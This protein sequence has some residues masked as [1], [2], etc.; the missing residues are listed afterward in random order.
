MFGTRK[1]YAPLFIL[2]I[3]AFVPWFQEMRRV[4]KLAEEAR[5]ASYP[6]YTPEKAREEHLWVVKTE[7]DWLNGKV[8][9]PST[10]L[11][12]WQYTERKSMLRDALVV[13]EGSKD[14]RIRA[15][16][17]ARLVKM[18]TGDE[19]T[20]IHRHFLAI[21][22]QEEFD[23]AR[24]KNLYY[25]R[26]QPEIPGQELRRFSE[27]YLYSIP[28]MFL[29]FVIR[30]RVRELMIWTE[31][32]RLIPA[33]IFW[34]IALFLYPGD[35]RRKEQLKSAMYFVAQFA[36]AMM[37]LICFGPIVPAMKAQI[38]KSGKNG[39]ER[40]E[41]K[42]SHTFAYGVEFYPQSAGID[43]GL[44]I[45][46]WYAHSHQLGKGFT[47]SGFGFIEAGE[48]KSQLFTNH[49]SN[50]SHEKARG[51]MFTWEIGGTTAGAFLGIGPRFNLVKLPFFPKD[52]KKIVKSVV[53]GSMWQIRGPTHYREFFLTWSSQEARLP[54]GFRL[55]TEGFM[56]FR[57][58][59]RTNVGQ[60]Q[61]LLRHPRIPH[62]QFVSE[63]WMIG[64]QP[65]VRLGLQ[66]SK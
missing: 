22:G 52:G 24:P 61:L 19:M 32:W 1:W 29:V 11:P 25:N 59:A 35:I 23:K 60:P 51:G 13:L 17:G 5:V 10:S 41:R 34:P 33:S 7:H 53:A 4:N 49:I 56:R 20:Q 48:R 46:P 38:N 15:E 40:T 47:F 39:I 2:L 63:F 62:T 28:V 55:G 12:F 65:T 31:I 18:V 21:F 9:P 54:F 27:G 6:R 66:F 36:S 42:S 45:A 64:T 50:F 44:M 43:K 37:S 26:P 3:T 14:F 8:P 58:G 30:L 57:P 16:F